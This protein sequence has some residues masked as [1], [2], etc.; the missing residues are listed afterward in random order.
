MSKSAPHHTPASTIQFIHTPPELRRLTERLRAAR[1][2]GLDTEFIG[3]TSYAPILCLVQISTAEEV[4]LID[5]QALPDL[6]PLRELLADPGILK[7]FHAGAQ[8]LA[9]LCQRS[10]Q[11]GAGPIAPRGPAAVADT[12]LL[13]GL[14]GVGYPLSYGKAAEYFC[15][16]K[17]DKAHT[18]SDWSRRPLSAAQIQYA[19]D[20]VRYLLRIHESLTQ[21]LTAL[22]R[23]SWAEALAAEFCAAAAAPPDPRQAYLK[24]KVGK[25]FGPQQLAVLRE[26]AAWRE[27]IAFEHNMPVRSFFSDTVLRDLAR[28]MPN[29]LESLHQV[30]GFSRRE[31]HSYATTML[32]LIRKV[33][34][35]K[36]ESYPAPAPELDTS[37]DGA[38]FAESLWAAAQ[39]IC[40]G[41]SVCPAVV[42][43]Q[44]Q[45]LAAAGAI[46]RGG[47]VSAHAVLQG[48]RWDCL[49]RHLV[50]FAEGRCQLSLTCRQGRMQLISPA[51]AG[52]C[53]AASPNPRP[54]RGSKWE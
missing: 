49:G 53:N 22:N 40:L 3:E 48:W 28:L 26:L 16:A 38:A 31:L 23:V 24:I 52:S 17:L 10:A 15:G 51:V 11:G 25:G 44:A 46:R 1:V 18:Y 14:V 21:R 19:A 34:A 6:D 4:T 27:Q 47:D 9:I 41:Q 32:E 2:F 13:A 8:D 50:A 54:D 33:K 35:A 45:V 37:P 20:D 29:R 43:S 5:P 12:Q 36:P 42:A 39:A 7:I 30:D